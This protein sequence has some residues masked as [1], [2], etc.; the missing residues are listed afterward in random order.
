MNKETPEHNANKILQEY[1]ITSPEKLNLEEI[2]NA[3][4]LIVEESD[5]SNHLGRINFAGD[6]GLI[7]IDNKIKESGQKRFTIAHEMGH[8]FNEREN[9]FFKTYKCTAEDLLSL[10]INKRRE[11]D[12]NEFASEI[13]LPRPWF[14]EFI[15]KRK[16]DFEIIKEIAVRFNVSLTAAAI[17]YV[18]IGKFPVALI[19]STDGKVKW[20]TTSQYFPNTWI[21]RGYAVR[22]DAAAYDYFNGKETQTC[23]DLVQASVWFGEDLR[24]REEVYYN[25]QNIV[26][27]NYNSVLTLL[28]ESEYR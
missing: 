23:V 26:M 4:Y 22:K 15:K 5:L 25:E 10:K 16:I 2:A 24:T 27:K 9:N 28:W 18:E 1:G 20:S 13:L 3:E 19:M 17:R 12:A 11:A 21:P 7:K 8:Y 6:Y 14:S